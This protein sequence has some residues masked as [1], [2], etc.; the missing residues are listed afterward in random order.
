MTD[1]QP[2][3]LPQALVFD[4]DGVIADTEPLHLQS[5]QS[6]LSGLGLSVT[7][8]E[9]LDRYLGYTDVEVFQIVAQERGLVLPSG[10]IRRLVAAKTLRFQ[11][12]V[13]GTPV[14]FPGVVERV[15]EWARQVPVAVASG[16]LRAEIDLV[17]ESAG[18]GS[19]F[20]TIVSANDPVAGKPSP[21]PY[22]LALRQL[23][24]AV[25]DRAPRGG[26][27]PARC[28]AVEDSRWGAAAAKAAGMRVV[29]VTSSYPAA[30][31]VEADHVVDSV[32]DLSPDLVS[33]FLL[34]A[35]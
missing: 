15:R 31:L 23:A 9:Y 30:L 22:L 18:L 16:A 35:P 11:E 33:R 6:V 20:G 8:R 3:T 17:L 12:L 1:P 5:F 4:F 27:D 34:P 13:S 19:T 26:F 14:I 24:A 25:G 29:G 28:V 21:E 7:R 32:R 2:S 10:E